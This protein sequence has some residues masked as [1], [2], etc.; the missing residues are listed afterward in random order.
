T[1][2]A[3]ANVQFDGGVNSKAGQFNN[4]TV[5]SKGNISFGGELGN[6]NSLGNLTLKTTGASK[7]IQIDGN[8]RANIVT[9]TATD[10]LL[11]HGD[12]ISPG[13]GNPAATN[14]FQTYSGNLKIRKNV[15]FEGNI[16]VLNGVDYTIAAIPNYNGSNFTWTYR[17]NGG[18]VPPAPTPPGPAP[19][20]T[21]APGPGPAPA[22]PT[23]DTTGNL[24]R[25]QLAEN[26]EVAA[27]KTSNER[28]GNI[29]NPTVD[30]KVCMELNGCTSP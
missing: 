13:F 8:T 27:P 1:T 2:D 17:Y 11:I 28:D 3:Q 30:N 4:L 5:N 21:P 7:D 25:Y 12:I 15:T 18:V 9:L 24:L 19:A 16:G 10:E 23:A 14:G 22:G 20:P 29:D 6:T 26:S